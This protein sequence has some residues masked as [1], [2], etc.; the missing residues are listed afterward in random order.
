MKRITC[1][2]NEKEKSV[3]QCR[4][5]K[6][7]D[8]CIEDILNDLTELFK[9]KAAEKAKQIGEIIHGTEESGSK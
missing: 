6:Y 8:D 2:F 9:Q 4:T 3:N 1:P 7:R 5:C